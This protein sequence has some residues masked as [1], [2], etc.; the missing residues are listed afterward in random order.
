M[1]NPNVVLI[2]QAYAAYV[3]GETAAML[4]LIDPDLEWTYLDPSAA[5]PDR[6]SVTAAAS[7]PPSRST[8]NVA[9]W[10][11]WRR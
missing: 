9:C 8:P 7:W 11:S 6:G 2:R 5:D 10:P 1:P 4:D 3:R